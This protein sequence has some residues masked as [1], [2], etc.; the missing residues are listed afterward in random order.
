MGL[1]ERRAAKNFET[2]QLPTFKTQIDE[3]AGFSV[4][5]DVKWDT[6]ATDGYA[7]RY[8]EFFPQAYFKPL[9]NALKAIA[10]D[11]MGREAL[12]GALKKVIIQN[13]KDSGYA[14]GMASFVDG[15][16]TLDHS[17]S[18]NLHQEE[19]RARAIQQTLEKAL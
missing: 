15:V 13:T 5:L 11:D 6:I 18:S 17:P 9:V 3:A 19:D 12:Q 1:S 16:L 8:E 14:G 7:E 4:P 10:V 2:N